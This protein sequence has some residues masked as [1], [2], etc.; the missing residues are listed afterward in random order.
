MNSSQ[1]TFNTEADA[2]SQNAKILARLQAQVGVDDGFVGLPELGNVSG[3]WAVHS[4]IADLRRLGHDIRNRTRWNA[5][6]CRSFYRL[7]DQP[8]PGEPLKDQTLGELK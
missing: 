2:T 8:L 3:S 7:E 5:G 1:S 4:R 6:R